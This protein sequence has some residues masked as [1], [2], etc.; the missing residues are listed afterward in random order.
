MGDRYK[1]AASALAMIII[2]SAASLPSYSSD[3]DLD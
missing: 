1:W 2:V 3:G